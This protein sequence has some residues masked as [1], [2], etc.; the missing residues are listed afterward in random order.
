MRAVL[1]KTYSK[2]MHTVWENARMF[3]QLH[4]QTFNSMTKHSSE[5]GQTLLSVHECI[6]DCGIFTQVKIKW[7]WYSLL[8]CVHPGQAIPILC[9]KI[10]NVGFCLDRNYLK[11][12]KKTSKTSN[13]CVFFLFS[14]SGRS[15]RNEEISHSY[16]SLF[17]NWA[18]DTE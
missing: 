2:R 15:N 14:W 11:E 12:M 18:V 10:S 5:N 13:I 1:W 8:E 9:D 7:R 4:N 16:P 17:L 3:D 6:N